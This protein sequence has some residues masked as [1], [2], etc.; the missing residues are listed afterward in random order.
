MIT[1]HDQERL[2]VQVDFIEKIIFELTDD[3]CQKIFS[4]AKDE[5]IQNNI[6]HLKHMISDLR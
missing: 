1:K 6:N 4:V 5:A 2:S 3:V